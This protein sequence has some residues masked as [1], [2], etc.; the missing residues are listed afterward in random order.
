[1]PRRTRRPA[2]FLR[3]VERREHRLRARGRPGQPPVVVGRIRK[4][5]LEKLPNGPERELPLERTPSRGQHAEALCRRAR[6]QL[7]EQPALA[8]PG[9]ALDQPHRSPA[10]RDSLYELF[11][12]RDIAFALEKRGSELRDVHVSPSGGRRKFYGRPT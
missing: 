12:R 1:M 3:L 5:G 6:L 9:G 7:G 4:K 8:D 10:G 11:E 2:R